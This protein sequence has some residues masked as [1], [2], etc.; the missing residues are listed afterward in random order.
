MTFVLLIVSRIANVAHPLILGQ[1][2]ANISC[3]P[4]HE[5]NKESGCPDSHAIYTM[6]IV[7]ACTKFGAEFLNYMREIPFA[8]VSANAELHIATLVYRHI[9][10]QSLAFHLSRET[11]KVIRI[12]SKGSQSFA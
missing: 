10:H 4:E 12:V 1:I 8:Y 7:Y 5:L 3:D 11:G 6:I 2:V 9:Q